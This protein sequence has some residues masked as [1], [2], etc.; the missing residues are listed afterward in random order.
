M[1]SMMVDNQPKPFIVTSS[2]SYWS[3]GICDCFE[4]LPQCCLAFWCLP[5]FSCKTTY[6]AGEPLCLSLLDCCGVL[7]PVNASLRVAIRH[8]YGI[9]DTLLKDLVYAWCCRPCSWCQIARELKTRAIPNS[10]LH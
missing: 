7:P 6:E 10:Q 9:E 8:R 1:T 3:S 4:D 2:S 5:C